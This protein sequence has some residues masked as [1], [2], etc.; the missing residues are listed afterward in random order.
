M[1]FCQ[2]SLRLASFVVETDAS[3]YA[4]GAVLSFSLEEGMSRP[5][6]FFSR[7]LTAAEKNY[8]TYKK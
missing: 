8:F 5:V 6:T 1:C 4:V 7:V 3:N 2:G